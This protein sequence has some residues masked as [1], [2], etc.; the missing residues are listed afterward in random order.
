[1]IEPTRWTINPN[2]TL[3][4][5]TAW[6][7]NT[8][9]CELASWV[10]QRFPWGNV[11]SLTIKGMERARNKMVRDYILKAPAKFQDILILD[12]DIRPTQDS[13]FVLTLD[14]DL[15]SCR[16][17]TGDGRHW[18]NP[19]AFHMGFARVRRKVFET[20]PPPWFA[21]PMSA[22]GCE[23][24]TCDCVP[25]LERALEAGFTSGHAGWSRHDNQGSWGHTAAV[26]SD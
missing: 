6:P 8:I 21:T 23:Y 3:V 19:N 11:I 4:L 24:R 5:I 25:F 7:K 2:D 12:N 1:M 13:D 20:L 9:T 17:D 22:D 26:V 15:A 14:T 18:A 10:A 16:Y